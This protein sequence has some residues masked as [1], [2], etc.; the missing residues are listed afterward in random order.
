M[1][2]L[3]FIPSQEMN[4][5]VHHALHVEPDSTHRLIVLIPDG[6]D[7]HAATPRVWELANNTRMHVQLLGLVKDVVEE[8]SLHRSLVTMA[9]LIQDGRIHTEAK[10]EIGTNWLDLVKCNYRAGDMIVCFAEQRTGLL[11]RPLS[12]MIQSRWNAPLYIMS[13]LCPQERTRTNWLNQFWAWSGSIGII[14]VS[15]LFQIRIT[16]LSQDW[17]Q[18]VLLIMS[19]LAEIWLIWGWNSLLS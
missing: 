11:H 8:L 4:Q 14:A 9:A 12:Q 19:V 16:S 13:G 1:N 2:K 17:T 5:T 18:T 15:A 10:T 3:D 7:F 6:L